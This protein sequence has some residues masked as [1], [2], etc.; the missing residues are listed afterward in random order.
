MKPIIKEPVKI[1]QPVLFLKDWENIQQMDL[2]KRLE[3]KGK[4]FNVRITSQ[5][6]KEFYNSII[7]KYKNN[8][9]IK[10]KE[11][12]KPTLLKQYQ[13]FCQYQ[14]INPSRL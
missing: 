14:L 8:L 9:D 11:F 2:I 1:E 6:E 3:Y 12:N 10:V 5:K 13:L 4:L 7:T